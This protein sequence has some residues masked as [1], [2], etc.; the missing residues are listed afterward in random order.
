[1]NIIL[2]GA[3]GSGKGTQSNLLAKEYSIK[4]ISTGDLLRKEIEEKSEIGIVVKDIMES[5]KLVDDDIVIEIIK[6]KLSGNEYKNGFILDGFPRNINQAEKLEEMLNKINKK[7][8]KVFNFVIE[9]EIAVKRI[10]GRYSCK[11][12]GAVY[13]E[14]FN[15]PKNE[16]E[17]DKCNSLEFEKRSDDN[18]AIVKNRLQIFKK[19]S[20]PLIEF[21]KK[22]YL[23]VS[24]DALKIAPLIFEDLK[25]AINN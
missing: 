24:V 8:D 11:K 2:I 6:N 7:I 21:Y 25:S 23:L 4:A 18:E 15:P 12:C 1:M 10:A 22:K 3:P 13:N 9:D 19:S 20:F 16:G 5:G 17:C 14:Y